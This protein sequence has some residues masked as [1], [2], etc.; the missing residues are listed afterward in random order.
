MAFNAWLCPRWGLQTR[1]KKTGKCWRYHSKCFAFSFLFC[2]QT[3]FY[4]LTLGG[5]KGGDGERGDPNY[6]GGLGAT[7]SGTFLLNKDDALLLVVGQN[8]Q[9]RPSFDSTTSQGGGGGGK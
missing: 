7:V 3:A 4:R 5:A 8:G 9:F 1:K 6:A 2:N